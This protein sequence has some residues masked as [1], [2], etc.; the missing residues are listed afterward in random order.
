MTNNEGNLTVMLQY[1]NCDCGWKL[2]SIHEI[3]MH[4]RVLDLLAEN[5][6]LAKNRMTGEEKAENILSRVHGNHYTVS[7]W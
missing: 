6:A 1:P 3:S 2:L 7:S 4:Y 5:P